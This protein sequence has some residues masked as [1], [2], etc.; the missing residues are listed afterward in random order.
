MSD[1]PSSRARAVLWYRVKAAMLRREALRP[2]NFR[3]RTVLLY[4]ATRCEWLAD[5][6][7]DDVVPLGVDAPE[8]DEPTIH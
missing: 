5:L 7:D 4:S 6:A 3:A 2:C 1:G 8:S